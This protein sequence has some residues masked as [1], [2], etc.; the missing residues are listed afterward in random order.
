MAQLR[1]IKKRIK[2]VGN[3]QRITKT[4]QMI[5]T[6]KFQASVK[7]SEETKPYT[8]KIAEIVSELA[9]AAGDAPIEH[10][11]L[12]GPTPA[13]GK[14]LLLVLTSNRGFCGAYNTN[15][16]RKA[17]GFLMESGEKM[18]LEVVGK[19]GATFFR[20]SG[21][22]PEK[23][24]TEFAD[25]VEYDEVEEIASDYIERFSAG[26]FDA[27]HVAYMEFIS[28]AK[29]TPRIVKLLPL[30]PPKAEEGE[31][32]AK[33]T[34]AVYEFSPDP[35]ELLGDLL[36]LTVKSKLF[37]YFNDAVV[38]EQ[39]ARMVAMK[40]ATDNA[41]K[42]GTGLKRS[43]NRARQAQITTELSEIISGAAALD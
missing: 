6:V 22:Q 20:F 16:L 9:G 21:P 37:E 5:A 4:M 18:A 40:A 8:Q 29:Q 15:V 25:K 34:Q 26:E 30:E 41:G 24:Y 14:E 31:Q 36:P 11:L 13:A 39:I 33:G 38:S 42:V 23:A 17:A 19:K 7:R 2:A 27:V 1:E 32:D 10:P 28:N 3:I 35:A 12:A 43:F